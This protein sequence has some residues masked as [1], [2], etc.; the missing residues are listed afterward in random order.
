MTSALVLILIFAGLRASETRG[1]FWS[2]I[3]LRRG[4]ITVTRRADFKHVIGPPKSEA[5]FRSIP[6]PLKVLHAIKAW[7]LRCPNTNKMLVFPSIKGSVMTHQYMT[8]IILNP[9][10]VAAGVFDEVVIKEGLV[11]KPRYTLHD[12]RHSA[13]SLWIDRNVSP[14]LIQSWM[15]HSSIT[16]TFDMYGHLFAKAERDATAA[17]AIEEDLIPSRCN[18]DAT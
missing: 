18:M 1:L 5:G 4:L 9:L 17:N 12:F 11:E 15:G 7:R 2:D 10:Q 6:L 8:C 3:D 13:A 16:V 14:K